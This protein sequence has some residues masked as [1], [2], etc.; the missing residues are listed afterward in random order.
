MLRRGLKKIDDSSSVLQNLN[1]TLAQR[2]ELIHN[3][4]TEIDD[5]SA[6]IVEGENI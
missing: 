5:L 3:K 6:K 1:E 2:K 4:V